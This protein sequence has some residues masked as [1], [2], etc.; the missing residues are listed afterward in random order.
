M[1]LNNVCRI[2]LLRNGICKTVY[3]LTTIKY[4]IIFQIGVPLSMMEYIFYIF[5]IIQ[6]ESSLIKTFLKDNNL[7]NGFFEKVKKPR[8]KSSS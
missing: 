5:L 4:I 2:N 8:Y 3:L 1:L 7:G 6:V